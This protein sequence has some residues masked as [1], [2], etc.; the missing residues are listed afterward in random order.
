MRIAFIGQH[1]Y[2]R[3]H[4]G[5]DLSAAHEVFETDFHYGMS[6]DEFRD[7]IAFKPE[8]T[9]F[10]RGEFV[11]DGLLKRL[12][13]VTVNLSSEPFPKVVEGRLH[14]NDSF[15]ERLRTFLTIADKGFDYVFHYDAVSMRLLERLGV[16]LSGAW[17]FPIATGTVDAYDATSAVLPVVNGGFDFLFTGRG[18]PHR[19][20]LFGALKHEFDFLHVDS[21]VPGLNAL[22]L[23][24]ASKIVIN[25]HADPGISWE[26]RLQ[27]FLAAGCFVLSETISENPYLTPGEH[28]V[29][30][31]D[32]PDLYQKARYYLER[33]Q[34]REKIAKA[35]QAR[36]REAL[37]SA[38]AFEALIGDLLAGRYPKPRFDVDARQLELL[39]FEARF[40]HFEFV[41]NR[42]VSFNETIDP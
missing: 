29:A 10:F 14:S 13:G 28:F 12:S 33:P 30:F 16:H 35:G 38:P 1:E 17:A 2:F 15:V 34:L 24:R 11:P 19:E 6:L 36:V 42:F 26:P 25:A 3:I 31:S 39:S 40:P 18:T 5:D 4:Y 27:F 22:P 7:L 20:R 21:G 41:A 23:A 32:G 8:I 9:F 37:A